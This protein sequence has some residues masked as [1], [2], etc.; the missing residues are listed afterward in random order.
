[1]EDNI[2]KFMKEHGMAGKGDVENYHMALGF[3]YAYS[4]DAYRL[5]EQLDNGEIFDEYEVSAVI[6]LLILAHETVQ[7]FQ[8]KLQLQVNQF[9]TSETV[10]FLN[11]T[12]KEGKITGDIENA[13]DT[14]KKWLRRF[15][16]RSSSKNREGSATQQDFFLYE[17]A[18]YI[19]YATGKEVDY[20]FLEHAPN[21]R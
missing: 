9:D 4:V 5:A 8:K 16:S 10:C 7:F 17:A 1:M 2:K 20:R 21:K 12:L 19:M 11:G 13:V 3:Y 15:H 14:A 6:K 18:L